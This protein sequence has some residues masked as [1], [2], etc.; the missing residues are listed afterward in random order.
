L[1]R[2]VYLSNA[3]VPSEKANTKQSMLQCEALGKLYAVEFWHPIR[4][5]ALAAPDVHDFYGLARTFVMRPIRCVDSER[6]RHVHS[7]AAF[8]LQTLTFLMACAFRIVRVPRGTVVYSRN[9]F[10]LVLAAMLRLA[11]ADVRFFFEDH[12]GVLRRFTTIKKMFLSAVDGIVVTTPFHAKA[13]MAAGVASEKILTSPNAV[14]LTDFDEPTPRHRE[15]RF[16]VVYAGNLFPWKG[17]FVLADAATHLPA[18]Y[19]VE[20]IGGSTEAEEPFKLYVAESTRSGKVVMR[21]YLP[22]R[23]MPRALA[24]ADVLVLPNSARRDVSATFTSPLKLFE[25]MAS[26]RPIVASDVDAVREILV[27]ERNAILVPADDSH[28]LADAIR[29][30]CE[31]RSLGE[32]LAAQARRD[33][34]GWTWDSRAARIAQF[35]AKRGCGTPVA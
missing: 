13:L 19:V 34:D 1:T 23:Q 2:L 16:H 8:F 7:R 31:D 26:G 29:R 21:G 17:V 32:Q 22:P 18:S 27:H 25:Y 11:R 3:R 20:F 35:V 10:D 12:D 4:R 28:A 9:P 5:T 33:V 24:S 30:V 6:L 14:R 15:R